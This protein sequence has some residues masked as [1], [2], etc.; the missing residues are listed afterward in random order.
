MAFL[1]E[2]RSVVHASL[3]PIRLTPGCSARSFIGQL[4]NSHWS[5]ALN[6]LN[7]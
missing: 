6:D 3:L 1:R 7:E 4:F 2:T 5:S